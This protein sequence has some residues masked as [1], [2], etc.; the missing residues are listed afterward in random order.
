MSTAI[1]FPSN[2]T[3]TML[4]AGCMVFSITLVL[5]MPESSKKP[6]TDIVLATIPIAGVAINTKQNELKSEK[7]QAW[8]LVLNIDHP[9]ISSLDWGGVGTVF[10][11]TQRQSYLETQTSSPYRM[12]PILSNSSEALAV[13]LNTSRNHIPGDR[14]HKDIMQANDTRKLEYDQ[15]VID[16][17]STSLHP[18]QRQSASSQALPKYYFDRKQE[19][20]ARFSRRTN[21]NHFRLITPQEIAHFW[22]KADTQEQL[23][24]LAKEACDYALKHAD[25]ASKHTLEKMNLLER[26]MLYKFYGD[27]YCYLRVWLKNSIQF[28]MQMPDIGR[29]MP[30]ASIYIDALQF[31]RDE[32]IEYFLISKSE[33]IAIDR[34]SAK[35]IRHYLDSLITALKKGSQD[36]WFQRILNW[37]VTTH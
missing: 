6:I 17:E 31:L 19:K 15:Q 28:G 37:C 10:A 5:Q 23:K 27:I 16:V 32:R 13:P 36:N 9:V 21:R 20:K 14:Q 1:L 25:N 8:I 34:T 11:G 12:Q 4:I 22:T 33:S 29:S 7:K 3:K 18:S 35:L 2:L 26:E 24:A 30:E